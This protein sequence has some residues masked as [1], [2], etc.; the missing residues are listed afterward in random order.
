MST[1]HHWRGKLSGAYFLQFMRAGMEKFGTKAMV[2]D[3]EGHWSPNV[4]NVFKFIILIIEL[5]L[6]FTRLN[7]VLEDAKK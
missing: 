2:L 1:I 5:L 3:S 6:I 4:S 7:F